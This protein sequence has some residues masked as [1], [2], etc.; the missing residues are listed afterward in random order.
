MIDR[1]KDADL[2]KIIKEA[3]PLF[4]KLADKLLS[5]KDSFYSKRLNIYITG[6]QRIGKTWF[7][8][9]LL[10]E[11]KKR[12]NDKSVMYVTAVDLIENVK[13]NRYEDGGEFTMLELYQGKRL[14]VIDDLGQEYRGSESGYAQTVIENLIRFRFNAG[15]ITYIGTNAP[16]RDLE[17]V[18]SQSLYKFIEGEFLIVDISDAKNISEVILDAKLSD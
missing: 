2:S 3:S 14:L 11:I 1:Y 17:D 9:A 10:N 5:S 4:S 8:H 13:K 12:F 15:L 16:L 7:F 18:Y 6:P